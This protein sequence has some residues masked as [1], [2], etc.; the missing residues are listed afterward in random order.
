VTF[1]AYVDESEPRQD[2]DPGTYVLCAAVLSFDSQEG[3]RE[4]MRALKRPHQK[5]VHWHEEASD[6]GR[7]AL[8]DSVAAMA[9][10][11][12]VVVRLGDTETRSERRRR[13]CLE[14]L[15]YE[16]HALGVSDVIIESRGPSDG[17]DRKLVDTMRAKKL[18][19]STLRIE[20]LP[21]PAEPLLW[22][23][24]VVC[25]AV[26]QER[27]G[28]PVYMDRLRRSVTIIEV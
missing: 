15:C 18:I 17:L 26:A 21:G 11:H 28:N 1:V 3:H 7:A 13:L 25:G 27:Y 6:K 12:L 16:L 14:R 23:P 4:L 10:E 19:D 24:D 9:A 22:V 20:H 5:K 2:I 8:V